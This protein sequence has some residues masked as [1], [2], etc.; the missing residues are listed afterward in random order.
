MNVDIR[1]EYGVPKTRNRAKP[2]E[3]SR[4]ITYIVR[5]HAR[6]NNQIHSLFAVPALRTQDKT[7]PFLFYLLL[8]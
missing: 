5:V 7:V 1:V 4:Y 8:D 6:K 3:T 2:N